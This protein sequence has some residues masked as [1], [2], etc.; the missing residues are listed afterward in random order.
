MNT[1][2]QQLTEGKRSPQDALDEELVPPHLLHALALDYVEELISFAQEEGQSPDPRTLHALATTR[3]WLEGHCDDAT[4]RAAQQDAKYTSEEDP[5]AILAWSVCE[6]NAAYALRAIIHYAERCSNWR[7]EQMR[8][9]NL[10]AKRLTRLHAGR[11]RLLR[12]LSQ[13]NAAYQKLDA[14]RQKLEDILF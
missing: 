7:S 10:L 9:R 2:I 14:Q 1:L 13:H 12:L 6:P 4:Q 8:Q 11:A 5:I 3:R